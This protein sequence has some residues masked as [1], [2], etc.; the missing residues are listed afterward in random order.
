MCTECGDK[1]PDGVEV[2]PDMVKA[3]LVALLSYDIHEPEK[4]ELARAVREIFIEMD[5]VR[6]TGRPS[7][8]VEHRLWLVSDL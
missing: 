7:A 1:K 6:R 2:T 4:G 5:G 8:S 3:G